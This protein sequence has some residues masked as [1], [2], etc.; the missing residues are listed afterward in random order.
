M[1]T[2]IHR[3]AFGH[4]RGDFRGALLRPGEEGYDEARR[5]WNGA[6]DRRPALIARC[7][8]ADDVR[9]AVRFA[10]DQDLPIA[11]RGGGHSVQGYSVADGGLTIDLSLLKAVE[12][13][14]VTATARVA[15]GL[16]WAEFDLATQ[17]HGL[18]TTGGSVSSTGIAGVTLGGGFGHLMRRYGLSADNLRGATL[19]TAEGD[20]VRADDDLLWALRGGGGNF[21]IVTSF[22]FD[23]HPVGPVVLGGPMFWSLDRA[24]AVLEF[25]HEW[26]PGAPDELGVALVATQSPPVPALAGTP[27]VG[28]LPVWCGDLAVGERVLAPLRD[29]RPIADLVRP[30]PYR[31]VQSLL[32]LAASPGLCSYWRSLRMPRLPVDVVLDLAATLPTPLSLLNGW[33]IGGAASRVAP[34]ATAVGARTPGFELRLIANWTPGPGDGVAP[35]PGEVAFAR[36]EVVS[37]RGEVVS[38]RGD[39]HRD[40]VRRGWERLRPYADGQFA[41]FLSDEDPVTAY[42]ESLSRLTAAKDRWDPQNV[43]RLN[44]NI[45]PSVRSAR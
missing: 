20:L 24:R 3:N 36:G 25:L 30:M 4:L 41:T 42:G 35:T 18:A 37:A 44:P 33:V 14:P 6:F 5:V 11:V 43:F 29:L 16:T 12:V 13:D 10:R 34:S 31:A 21:G 40:W 22:E 38:A 26:A 15:A 19:V 2:T 45:Q 1:T 23:L 27:V 17:R 8:G 32:D 9:R 28:L 39:G 7:A